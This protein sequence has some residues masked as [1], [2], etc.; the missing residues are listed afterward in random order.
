MRFM[1]CVERILCGFD[2]GIQFTLVS[3]PAA[4]PHWKRERR[5]AKNEACGV[6][7][8]ACFQHDPGESDTS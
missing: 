4:G 1:I 6:M 5:C 8:E 2:L 3:T 7:P